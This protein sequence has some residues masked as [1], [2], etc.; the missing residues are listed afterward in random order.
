MILSKAQATV[1]SYI[2]NIPFKP[3]YRNKECGLMEVC[4]QNLWTTWVLFDWPLH[5]AL[6]KRQ[7]GLTSCPERYTRTPCQRRSFVTFWLTKYTSCFCSRTMNSV[8]GVIQLES[9]LFSVGKTSPL[10]MA[11]FSLQMASLADLWRLENQVSGTLKLSAERRKKNNCQ[12]L[13]FQAFRSLTN[14]VTQLM[15]GCYGISTRFIWYV[16]SWLAKEG[17]HLLL[18]NV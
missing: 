18:M 14:S 3:S 10:E 15:E 7:T 16:N 12:T 1:Q 9:N 6:T 17:V 13:S 5:L 8:P 2:R 11:S 4:I